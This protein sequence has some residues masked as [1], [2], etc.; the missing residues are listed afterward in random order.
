ML[1]AGH[2]GPAPGGDRFLG[3][4]SVPNDHEDVAVGQ[5]DHV[6]MR[7]LAGTEEFEM[8]AQVSIPG[9]FLDP[10]AD[11]WTRS[12]DTGIAADRGGAHQVTVLEQ[13]SGKARRV[14]GVPCSYD[15][16]Q[17]VDEVGIGG[18]EWG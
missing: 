5:P 7:K 11:A 12:K 15:S 6:M 4:L 13:E 8:P 14:I 9:K 2:L 16:A 17:H 1:V 18:F 3:C 10:A